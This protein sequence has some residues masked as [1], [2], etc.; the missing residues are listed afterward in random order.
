MTAANLPPRNGEGGLKRPLDDLSIT[1]VLEIDCKTPAALKGPGCSRSAKS[2]EVPS[3]PPRT[4]RDME[5]GGGPAASNW[6]Q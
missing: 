1:A 6:S 2:L 3:H 4:D 5:F